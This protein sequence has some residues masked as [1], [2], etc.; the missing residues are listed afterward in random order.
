MIVGTDHTYF[1]SND[2]TDQRR[3]V[4]GYKEDVK[5]QLSV[6]ENVNV[7]LTV[8]FTTTGLSAS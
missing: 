1:Y 5:V 8:Y 6:K 2:I 7:S 3:V 4:S